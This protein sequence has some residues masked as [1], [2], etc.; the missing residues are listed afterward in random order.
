MPTLYSS[1]R[2]LGNERG[3]VVAPFTV[4]KDLPVLLLHPDV[5][6]QCSTHEVM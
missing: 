5:V 6:R 3:F 2:E 1:L 4:G